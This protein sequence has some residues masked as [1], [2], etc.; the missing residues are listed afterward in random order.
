MEQIARSGKVVRGYLGVVVQNLTPELAKQFGVSSR[1]GALISEVAPASP[2]EQAG[3]HR[4]DI[5]VELNGKPLRDQ[6]EL[7][8][9]VSKMAPKTGI[10]LT[11]LRDGKQ[12]QV[13]VTLGEQPAHSE[14]S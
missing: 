3:L 7:K 11:I 5:V 4:G 12:Q 8:L 10:N 6:R 1:T 9:N 13:A 14:N 2:A